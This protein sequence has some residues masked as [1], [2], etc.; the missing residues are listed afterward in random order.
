MEQGGFY[1]AHSLSFVRTEGGWL[2]E[3]E[4]WWVKKCRLAIYMHISCEGGGFVAHIV[5]MEGG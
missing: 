2:F 3:A 1:F 4:Q 5:G